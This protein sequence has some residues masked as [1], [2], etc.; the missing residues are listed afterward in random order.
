[1]LRKDLSQ[2]QKEHCE[3]EQNG[4]AQSN[5][6]STEKRGAPHGGLPTEQERIEITPNTSKHSFSREISLLEGVVVL[7]RTELCCC[8]WF[9]ESV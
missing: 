2:Q 1:M 8:C 9:G 7:L 3:R 6:L 5:L 4:N